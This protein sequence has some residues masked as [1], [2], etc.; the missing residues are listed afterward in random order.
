MK[1]IKKKKYE[2]PFFEVLEI[3]IE[4]GLAVSSVSAATPNPPELTEIEGST[5]NYFDI[6]N[7]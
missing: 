1:F 3:Q 7:F 2:L 4:Q 6:D 5:N